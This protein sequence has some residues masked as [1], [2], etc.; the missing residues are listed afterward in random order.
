MSESSKSIDLYLQKIGETPL[1]TADEEKALAT[2]TKKGDQSA[3]QKLIEANLRFVV[4]VAKGYRNQGL[5][6]LDLIQEGNLGL[7][8]AIEKFDETLG[9]RLTTYIGWWI[10]L[11]V[12]R[13]IEQKAQPIKVPINK[14]ETLR[15]FKSFTNDFQRQ[16]G[17][18]PTP[19]EIA[20]HFT[21]SL[22]KVREVLDVD[23]AFYSLDAPSQDD[24][25]PM[26]SHL[27]DPNTVSPRRNLFEEQAGAKLEQAMEVLNSRERK[28]IKWRFGLNGRGNEPAS[29]RKIG[30]WINLSAEGVRRIEE[31]AMAKLRR[32]SIQHRIEGLV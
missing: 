1:L 5:P 27:A 9:Y 8:E 32:P 25:P 31:Q 26:S 20:K 17:A 19:E 2:R 30:G 11:A 24:L 14:F 16:K 22:K 21:M 15:K 13:A 28:V 29:L 6:L 3:K 4:K 18:K 10:R 23:T 12:Q 7:I